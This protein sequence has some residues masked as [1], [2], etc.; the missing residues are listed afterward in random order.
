MATKAERFRSEAQRAGLSR[1]KGKKRAAARKTPTA[2][3]GSARARKA[4]VAFEETPSS[5]PPSRKST[6]KSMHRAKAATSLTSKTMLKK[7]SPHSRH[8]M[9]KPGPRVAR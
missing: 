1:T 5:I 7:T 9:G 2:A 4:T 3:H 8:D 6:R